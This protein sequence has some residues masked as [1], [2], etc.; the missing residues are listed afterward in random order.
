MNMDGRMDGWSLQTTKP[1]IVPE[2][3]FKGLS[4]L[5]AMSSFVRSPGLS[6][7]DWKGRLHLFSD[8]N[9]R[10][11]LEGHSRSLSLFISVLY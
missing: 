6:V 10:N 4:R 7:S 1:F 2:M 11:N 8:K 9:S 5:S 3:T